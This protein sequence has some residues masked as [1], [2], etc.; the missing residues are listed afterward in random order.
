MKNNERRRALLLRKQGY[1]L[2]Q[3]AKNLAISKSTASLWVG[4]IALDARAQQRINRTRALSRMKGLETRRNKIELVRHAYY[5]SAKDDFARLHPSREQMRIG[6]A[7]L[8]WGEGSKSDR[9]GMAFM[10]SDPTLV[11]V[12]L[13]MLRKGFTINEKKLRACVHLHAYHHVQREVAFW[14]KITKIPQSQFIKPYQKTNTGKH[15]KKEYHGCISL[16]YNRVELVRE[17]AMLKQ[18]YIERMGV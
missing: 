17:L 9:Y 18:A 4:S 7:L 12:F 16:R 10:N 3:I 14:S 1:S 8:Y 2:R 13:G 15:T 5:L 6:A 11:R